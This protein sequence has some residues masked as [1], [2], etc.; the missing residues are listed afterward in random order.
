M[1][2]VVMEM[3]LIEAAHL[4]SLVEQF[5]ALLEDSGAASTDPAVA[6]LVPDAYSDDPEAAEEFRRLTQADLLGRRG[7]D[8]AV[9]LATLLQD[10]QRLTPT[11]IVIGSEAD[12]LIIDLDS[13]QTAAWLRTLTSLRLVLASRLGIASEDDHD[14]DPR[15]GIYDWLGYRLDALVRALDG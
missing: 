13:D 3:S 6:R 4:T 12:P 2:R 8:A 7:A 11:G 1:T 10:G 14:D 5:A 15:F 9:V